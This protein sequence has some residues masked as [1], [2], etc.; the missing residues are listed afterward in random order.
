[1]TEVR[2][3]A[4]CKAPVDVAFRY[5]DDYRNVTDYWHGMKSYQPIGEP[6][7]GI[8][9]VFDSV[10]KVGPTTLKSTIKTVEWERDDRVVYQS[11]SGV[12]SVTRFEFAAVDATHSEV[13]FSIEFRL[14]G[15]ITSKALEKTLE[16]FIASAARNTAD[17]IARRVAAHHAA[18]R[19]ASSGE[20]PGLPKP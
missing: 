20:T 11:V 16:P 13:T 19:A 2:F 12:H 18:E 8:G 7:H 3:V 4:S 10:I 5:L 14:P 6:G 1:M 17:N 15:G 9:A